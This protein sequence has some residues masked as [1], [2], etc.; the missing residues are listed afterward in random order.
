[1]CKALGITVL[2]TSLLTSVD[3][4]STPIQISTIAD[5]WIH[6]SYLVHA[7]ERNRAL[8]IV[9]SRGTPHSNQVRELILSNDGITLTDAYTADGEVLMGTLRWQKERAESWAE[10]TLALESEL[11][12]AE[13]DH[14]IREMS[15]QLR[16]LQHQID[17]KRSEQKSLELTEADRLAL[18]SQRKNSLRDRRQSDR[19]SP[20][21]KE[22]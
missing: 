5:T 17:N 7:G 13:L 12:R 4:E 8:S 2:N 1:M 6:L 9:K 20:N 3:E 19:Q 22:P 18:I 10:E 11:K 21:L 15:D 16:S 14:T